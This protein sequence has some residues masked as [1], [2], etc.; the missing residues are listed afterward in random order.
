MQVTAPQCP[1]PN[2]QIA[3]PGQN[4]VINS[5][6][7]VRGTASKDSFD[8]Y[9]FKFRRGDIQDEWH[10]VQ[11]FRVPVQNG[12]LG[13]WQTSHLPNGTYR[14]MLIAIDKTGNSQECTVSVIIQ[15]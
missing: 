14:F 12:D 4:Q 2:V 1:H 6:I 8:R 3:Q 13:W 7:Q 5:G 9:E 15:H 10:W 11:T